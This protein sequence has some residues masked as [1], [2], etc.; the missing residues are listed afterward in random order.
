[1]GV[2]FFTALVVAGLSSSISQIEGLVA[3]L[4]DKFGLPRAKILHAIAILGFAI[5]L[6][7]TTG[8]GYYWLDL[9]DHFISSYALVLVGFFEAL[10]VGWFFGARKL[11]E[12]VNA[13]SDIRVGAW[14]EFMI[15]YF[16]PIVLFVTFVLSLKS[17]LI[18][19]YGNYP[20]SAIIWVGVGSLLFTFLVAFIFYKKPWKVKEEF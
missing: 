6:L 13:T 15:K 11:R 18:H 5:G 20:M 9:V 4:I 10:V 16:I 17:D 19:R 7:Y 14:W 8:S 1:M 12:H 3:S 2:V